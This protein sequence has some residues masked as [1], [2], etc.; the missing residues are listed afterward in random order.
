MPNGTR[1]SNH[2]FSQTPAVTI[3][4]KLPASKNS[5]R[6]SRGVVV[7]K[8]FPPQKKLNPD[9]VDFPLVS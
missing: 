1:Y 7:P 5:S 9:L 4:E 6:S 3:N 2:S 8:N